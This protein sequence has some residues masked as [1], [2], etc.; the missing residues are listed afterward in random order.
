MP[1]PSRINFCRL[2]TAPA[3]LCGPA[4]G[5][6]AP[7]TSVVTL[8]SGRRPRWRVPCPTQ[9]TAATPPTR[10]LCVPG[11]M[12]HLVLLQRPP[13]SLGPRPVTRLRSRRP[14]AGRH[15]VLWASSG[16]KSGNGESPVSTRCQPCCPA[17]RCR[18]GP[19]PPRA[20]PLPHPRL[21]LG[22]HMPAGTAA[23]Q[24]ID[25]W[26][27]PPA[28]YAAPAAQQPPPCCRGLPRSAPL[29]RS[30]RPCP[31]TPQR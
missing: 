18:Q 27:V 26:V 13:G 16:D 12:Q 14:N 15:T 24:P 22:P 25:T 19:A 8:I 29:C 6:P 5:S 3:S 2:Y 11:T 28:A 30:R 31:S 23:A 10:S 20:T 21:A 1:R 7:Q 9:Q 17:S 4:H